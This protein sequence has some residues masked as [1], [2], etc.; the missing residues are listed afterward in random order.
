MDITMIRRMD[1]REKD[2][3]IVANKIDKIKKSVLNQQIAKIRKQVGKH[4]IILYSAQDKIG[5]EELFQEI[6]K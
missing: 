2:L 1:E 6:S 4:K 3:V 5:V